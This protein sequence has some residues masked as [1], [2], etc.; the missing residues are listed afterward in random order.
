MKD[1][2]TEN[3]LRRRLRGAAHTHRPDRERMLARVE[4]GMAEGRVPGARGMAGSRAP[5]S[6][7]TAGSR[8]PGARTADAPRP[9]TSWLRVVGTTAAVAGVCAVVGYGAASVLRTGAPDPQS[10]A[11]GSRPD[12]LPQTPGTR[13]TGLPDTPADGPSATTGGSRPTGPATHRPVVPP[14]TAPPASRTPK[15]PVRDRP[16]KPKSVPVAELLWADGSVDPGGNAHWGQSRITLRTKKPLTALTVELRVV[17]NGQ[18]TDTGNW[19]TMP[20]EDFTV[21]MDRQGGF[22][23]YR[24]TLKAGR[25]VPTGEHAFAGQYQ[26]AEGERDAKGDTYTVTVG[27][28]EGQAQWNGGFAHAGD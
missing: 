27:T 20:P 24:W 13:G 16:D 1:D 11:T 4:R 8:R 5:G 25:T 9:P 21:S 10:V 2:G 15:P 3:D 28:P 19:R 6:R 14:H 26:H 12:D 18:V 22:L 7:R 23:V 17:Q